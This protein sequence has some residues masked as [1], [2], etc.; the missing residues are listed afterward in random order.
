M[1]P[2]LIDHGCRNS[3]RVASLGQ[4]AFSSKVAYLPAVEAWK[5]A[6][7]KLLCWPDGSL[8]RQWC[9]G[10]VELLLLLLELSL[11]E[12]WAMAPILL[13]LSSMQLTPRWG[14]HHAIL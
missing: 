9:R 12:L 2:L 7:R 6:S 4:A 5:V 14:I 13:M 11:F 1:D 10:T 3:W 8:L